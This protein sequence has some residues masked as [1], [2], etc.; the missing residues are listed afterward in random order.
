MLSTLR[1]HYWIPHANSASRK[2]IKECPI[3]LLTVSVDHPP[4]TFVG[5]DYFGPIE[6]KRGRSSVKRYGVIFTCLTC[7]AVHIE[8]AHTM[9]TDSC[10]N[11][12]RRFICRRGQVKE[13]RSDNGTNFVSTN[14]EL[15]NALKE[16]NQS[17]FQKSLSNS[18][19]KW[20]FNAP[21]GAHHG[22]VC[23]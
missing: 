14:R 1:R 16:L 22:G 8:M 7:R 18:G 2:I 12:I 13:I 21:H 6:T 15:K 11:A 3:Y 4:F 23:A 5:M 9:D 10:I 17:K 19:I 20:T